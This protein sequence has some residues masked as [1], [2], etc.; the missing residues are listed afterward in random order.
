M[1]SDKSSGVPISLQ[2]STL[3]LPCDDAYAVAT[4]LNMFFLMKLNNIIM[5][6]VYVY[7]R[8][9]AKEGLVHSFLLTSVSTSPF[10][11]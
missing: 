9:Y 2:M 4:D 1:D 10:F 5:Q 7:R 11:M 3:Y 6:N 8:I